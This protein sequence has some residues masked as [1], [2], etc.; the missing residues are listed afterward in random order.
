[1]AGN[2]AAFPQGPVPRSALL[3]V[4]TLGTHPQPFDRV[5]D[6]LLPVIDDEELVVQHGA[7]EKRSGARRVRWHQFLDYDEL[8]ELIRTADV[9]VSHAGVGSLMTAIGLGSVPVAI[10]RSQAEG[11]H[12]DDH[13]LEIVSE[14]ERSEYVIPCLRPG[15]L[16]RALERARAAA[17]PPGTRP[18][19]WDE[20]PRGGLREAAISAAGGNPQRLAGNSD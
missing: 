14:L 16:P 17:P 5:L 6:W 12:V 11:E 9:V 7:T 10:P 8:A 1:M 18:L 3:I 15:D 19:I 4:C 20:S 2:A 13:Q